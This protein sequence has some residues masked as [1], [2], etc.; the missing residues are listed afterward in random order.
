MQSTLQINIIL[1][2]IKLMFITLIL[3]IKLTYLT[4]K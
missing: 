3:E 1:Y 4:F 2:I